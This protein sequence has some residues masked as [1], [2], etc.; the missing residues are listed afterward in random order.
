MN[1]FVNGKPRALR[2]GASVDDLLHE[3]RLEPLQVVIEH[4]GEPLARE[5]FCLTLQ[6]GDRL[7]IAQMVGGG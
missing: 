3:L 2:D 4:N 7:E 1:A 5:K 6:E